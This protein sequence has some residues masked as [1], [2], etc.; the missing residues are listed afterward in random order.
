MSDAIRAELSRVASRLGAD[1]VE[2]VLERPRDPT[3]GDLATNLPMVLARRERGNPRKIAERVLAD[4]HLP[5]DLVSKTEIAG[6]GF[7]NF[8]LAGAQLADAHRRILEEGP[9][10][11]RS[12]WGA[13][14]KVNVEFVSGEPDRSTSRGARAGGG[15]G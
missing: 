1:G 15:A 12:T 13:G 5:Q 10:Y 14:L 11:G 8:W 2:F 9:S 6:P 3:H 7:I 4:L